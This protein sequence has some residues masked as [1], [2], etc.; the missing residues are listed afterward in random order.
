MGNSQF[1]DTLHRSK[2]RMSHAASKVHHSP[3]SSPAV[4]ASTDQPQ[5][6]DSDNIYV[7]GR[8]YQRKN[9][10]Y[11]MPNDEEEQ[12]RLTN[13]HYLLKHCF[14]SNYSAPVRDLLLHSA[15]C[16]YAQ[17]S[18]PT[19]LFSQSTVSGSNASTLSNATTTNMLKHIVEPR[20]LDIACGTGIWV[21]EMC[22]D[23][24]RAQ[25]YGIDISAMYPGTIKPPNAH[26]MQGDVRD[27]LPFPDA[28][29]DYIHMQLVYNCFSRSES[30]RLLREIKRVLKPGGYVEFREVDP[31]LRNT[32][33]KAEKQY[34]TFSRLMIERDVDITW[35]RHMCESMEQVSELT[36]I[37]HQSLTI[38]FMASGMA[39][40]T[41]Y[42][43]V[44]GE[45]EGYRRLITESMGISDEEYTD[46]IKKVLSECT[47]KRAYVTYYMAWARKPIY[48]HATTPSPPPLQHIMTQ[49]DT[50]RQQQQRQLQQPT[51]TN[52]K[53]EKRKSS[54]TASTSQSRHS[55]SAPPT[56]SREIWDKQDKTDIEQFVHGYIE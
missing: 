17:R 39:G 45:M 34:Q 32:G 18:C 7:K 46:S 47:Q 3:E 23:F 55:V 27:G 40:E 21:L 12:D 54:G 14:G 4:S 43:T 29:F 42:S 28:H 49:H 26:F 30:D 13:V 50:Q 15:S 48:D 19:S 5:Q 52:Q 1:K 51:H 56:S 38:S 16:I 2:L 44:E 11:P 37:H 33:P 24:P 35:A 8:R 36:D 53:R 9:S 31:K 10:K 25:L 41:F 6:Q 20:V 22:S